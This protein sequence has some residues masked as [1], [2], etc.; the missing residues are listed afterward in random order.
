MGENKD[1]QH[2]TFKNFD[3][4]EEDETENGVPQEFASSNINHDTVSG[5]EIIEDKTIAMHSEDVPD[6]EIVAATNKP[7]EVDS[8][9]EKLSSV[10]PDLPEPPLE[11]TTID[12][13]LRYD[14]DLEL[15]PPPM[16]AELESVNY[17][18]NAMTSLK[19]FT[20]NDN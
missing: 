6:L 15:P 18:H 10:S 2:E 8:I 1:I 7:D 11:I 16:E 13:D 4:N 9:T 5:K 19:P 14:S 3:T 17:Q 12:T 20:D